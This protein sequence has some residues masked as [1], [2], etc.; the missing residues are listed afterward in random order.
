LQAV[1][2]VI[3]SESDRGMALLIDS[4]FGQ[5]RYRDLLPE[6]WNP[7]RISTTSEITKH[8]RQFWAAID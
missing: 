5:K 4:R 7:I 2:R 8:A 1:G 3:R 6:F